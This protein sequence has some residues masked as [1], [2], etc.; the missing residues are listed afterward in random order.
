MTLGKDSDA[1]ARVHERLSYRSSATAA[2]E[3]ES[4]HDARRQPVH[5]LAD[6]TRSENAGC[7]SAE[8]PDTSTPIAHGRDAGR[9]PQT[10][11]CQRGA[12]GPRAVSVPGPG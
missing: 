2:P 3:L 5:G 6:G 12:D 1:V 7:I 8:A 10:A 4:D 9:G 11:G